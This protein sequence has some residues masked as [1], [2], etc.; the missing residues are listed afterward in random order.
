MFERDGNGGEKRKKLVGKIKVK[1][2]EKEGN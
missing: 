1:V 2:K